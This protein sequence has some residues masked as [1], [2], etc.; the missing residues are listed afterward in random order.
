MVGKGW[1]SRVIL[2]G[3]VI[4]SK[5]ASM[6]EK[7]CSLHATVHVPLSVASGVMFVQVMS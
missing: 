7:E 3:S 1:A 5:G 2:E 6:I 4:V